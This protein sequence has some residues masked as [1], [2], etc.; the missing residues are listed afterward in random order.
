MTFMT[1]RI[2]GFIV[3]IPAV[4]LLLAAIA[5]AVLAGGTQAHEAP[6]AAAAPLPAAPASQAAAPRRPSGVGPISPRSPT[7][8]VSPTPGTYPL[9]LKRAAAAAYFPNNKVYVL[10]GRHGIDGEDTAL[11]WIWEYTPGPNAWALKNALLDGSAPIALHRQYGRRH[12]H[13]RQRRAH[14]CHRRQQRRQ[15]AHQHRAHLRPGGR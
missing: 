13:R 11:R 2:F 4:A 7:V 12:A 1:R 14:L 3:I 5:L 8:S 9:R 6:Q 10:G 15:R